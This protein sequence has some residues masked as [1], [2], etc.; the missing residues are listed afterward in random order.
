MRV[1][2]LKVMA[3]ELAFYGLE[4]PFL[5]L[6]VDLDRADAVRRNIFVGAPAV[7]GGRYATVGSS[8]AVFVISDADVT[9]LT[10]PLVGE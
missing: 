3:S 7:G 10:S 8:D 4:H 6:A 2:K 1:E 9:A 5:T